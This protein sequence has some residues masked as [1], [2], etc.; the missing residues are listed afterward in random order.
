V[1]AQ[2]QQKA[3]RFELTGGKGPATWPF[4]SLRLSL[5][6]SVKEEEEGLSFFPKIFE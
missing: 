3:A 1:R 4:L 6:R 5:R 2:L